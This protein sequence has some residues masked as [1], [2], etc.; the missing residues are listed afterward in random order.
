MVRQ[1]GFHA[2]FLPVPSSRLPS[3]DPARG[4]LLVHRPPRRH[5]P[6]RT[7]SGRRALPRGW[8]L[9]RPG[10]DLVGRQL[11][12]AG[13]RRLHGLSVPDRGRRLRE[14]R[15]GGL[16]RSRFRPEE[17]WKLRPRV[18][19]GHV[20]RR[21][22][23][24]ARRRGLGALRTAV[25]GAVRQSGEPTAVLPPDLHGRPER[26][27]LRDICRHQRLL[28]QRHPV[29]PATSRTA[30]GV[31]LSAPAA[32]SASRSSAASRRRIAPPPPPA[33]AAWPPGLRA[34]AARAS[35]SISRRIRAT[36]APVEW[37]SPSARAASTER[38]R[39][40]AS[41]TR[42]A[43]RDRNALRSMGSASPPPARQAARATTASLTAGWPG[44]AAGAAVLRSSRPVAPAPGA[45]RVIPDRSATASSASPD[46]ACP[47]SIVVSS[48]P[49]S[50]AVCAAPPAWPTGRIR[51]T[52]APAA[53]SAHR[54]SAIPIRPR[55]C[56]RRPPR[57]AWQ[58]AA[59]N[60]VCVNG[61]CAGS[62]CTLDRLPFCL[63]EDGTVGLC[64]ASGACA[65][66]MDDPQNCGAC[67]NVCPSGQSCVSGACS[68][69]DGC[70]PG[71]MSGFCNPDAGAGHACCPGVGCT[72]LMTD[73]LNCGACGSACPGTPGCVNG[74]CG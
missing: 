6:N 4:G 43:P 40:L 37:S 22:N 48:G 39:S 13:L 24:H 51:R 11:R 29:S 58:P 45:T 71:Q 54:E 23:L 41:R 30:A 55:V 14:L 61:T 3:A 33:P 18:P 53:T 70:G 62:D 44:R 20:L 21:R 35:V 69:F 34:T 52:A 73:A 74:V 38:H 8:R 27:D 66:P 59:S 15:L 25:H 68:G 26:P 46:R 5:L 1:G 60:A 10:R 2:A 49:P 50:A 32:R 31:E 19:G 56:R 64:C 67:G 42:A 7:A 65:H 12:G 36:A 72:D 16:P 17:L 47:R 9:V 63:A 28:L 57:I